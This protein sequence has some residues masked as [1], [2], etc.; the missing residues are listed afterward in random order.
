MYKQLLFFFVL[1]FL[2]KLPMLIDGSLAPYLLQQDTLFLADIL[3]LNFMA[4]ILLSMDD[5]T[6][7]GKSSTS[8]FLKV[9]F[10]IHSLAMVLRIGWTYRLAYPIHSTPLKG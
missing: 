1:V 7:R 2:V 8:L 6:M 5:T 3:I 4:L 10:L 9:W